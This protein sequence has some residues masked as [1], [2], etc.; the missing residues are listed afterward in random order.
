MNISEAEERWR[1][2]L[3]NELA[4]EMQKAPAIAV[5]HNAE[6]IHRVWRN[7][8][9]I[10]QA[11]DIDGE[12][13]IAA[14]FLHDLGRHYPEGSGV[15]GPISAPIARQVLDRI[16]FPAEKIPSA[17]QAIQYHDEVFSTQDRPLLEARV[18]YDADKL[19][20]FGAVGIAR[21]LV[22]Y[23]L[24]GKTMSEIASFAEQNL[25][26]R[27]NT[28]ELEETKQIAQE[29]ADYAIRYFHRLADE[30]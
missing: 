4:S 24:R 29:R 6:H 8:K 5:S 26:L 10:A 19:D 13:L 28:L 18:L 23:S 25:P 22:F 27:F 3:E 12:I 17:V 7:A 2:S 16:H 21:C 1:Q 11:M 30:L 15:H 14:V 9:E 20:A